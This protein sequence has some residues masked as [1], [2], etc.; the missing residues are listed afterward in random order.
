MFY[1][2][3]FLFNHVSVAKLSN[4][5]LCSGLGGILRRSKQVLM[6]KEDYKYA[7]LLNFVILD[8]IPA[9]FLDRFL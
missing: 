9:L 5:K 4:K 3:C 1:L 8:L 2:L 7:I 6:I